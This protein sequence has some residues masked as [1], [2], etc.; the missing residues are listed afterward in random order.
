MSD[1]HHCVFFSSSVYYHWKAELKLARQC[2]LLPPALHIHQFI[3]ETLRHREEYHLT[4]P[5]MARHLSWIFWLPAWQQAIFALVTAAPVG[6][7]L[8]VTTPPD[9]F[10]QK[11]CILITQIAASLAR[12]NSHL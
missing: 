5:S 3:D 8:I 9:G 11:M 6:S 1:A 12:A 10:P 4:P 7:S 2:H